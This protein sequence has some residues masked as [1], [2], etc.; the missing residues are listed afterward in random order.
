MAVDIML[1]ILILSAALALTAITVQSP[2]AGGTPRSANPLIRPWSGPY[3]GVPPWDLAKPELFPGAF[4]AALAEQR[5]EIDAIAADASA[6]TFENT[7][8]A[9]E[10]AGQMLDRVE[11]SLRGGSPEHQHTGNPGARS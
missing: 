9:M 5:A 7:I 6:P 2:A 1:T 10:R 3:G 11:P 4:E 8:A